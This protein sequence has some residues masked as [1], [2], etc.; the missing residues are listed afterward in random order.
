[1]IEGILDAFVNVA[2]YETFREGTY[3]T[4]PEKLKSKKAIINNDDKYLTNVFSV[5]FFLLASSRSVL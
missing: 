1:M 5:F 4:L 2:R 3:F